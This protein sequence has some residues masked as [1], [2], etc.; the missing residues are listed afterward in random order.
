MSHF[1]PP[2]VVHC[3]CST[4][5]KKKTIFL[6]PSTSVEWRWRQWGNCVQTSACGLS[7]QTNIKADCVVI[8]SEQKTCVLMWI[9]NITSGASHQWQNDRSCVCP[10]SREWGSTKATTGRV[11]EVFAWCWLECWVNRTRGSRCS[12]FLVEVNGP[13]NLTPPNRHVPIATTDSAAVRKL[14]NGTFSFMT[15]SSN[16]GRDWPTWQVSQAPRATACFSP[17]PANDGS[18]IVIFLCLPPSYRM[19]NLAMQPR[20]K[21][22]RA[23]LRVS[24]MLKMQ[25]NTKT[26]R[27]CWRVA[28][29]AETA[30]HPRCRATA[31]APGPATPEVYPNNMLYCYRK[32]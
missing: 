25:P 17:S 18:V 24:S 29:M 6:F 5:F 1:K 22:R 12:F 27:P 3:M 32:E 28:C 7:S 10:T 15:N 26:W 11:K 8:K 13:Q 9:N 20:Q 30:A 21:H 4:P 19:A 16:F 23:S 2:T 14:F 31:P